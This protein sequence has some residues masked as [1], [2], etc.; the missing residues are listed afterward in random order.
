MRYAVIGSN[1]FS[2]SHFVARLLSSKASVL[3][4]SRS[5]EV[6]RVFRPYSWDDLPGSWQFAQIDIRDTP[7]LT[8]VL[9]TFDPQ[10]V[11]NFAAQSMVA[12]SWEHPDHWYRTNVEALAMLAAELLKLPNLEK[13]VQVTTP[14]VY[15]S[16]EGWISESRNF[17][18]STPYAVSRAAGDMHLMAMH[19]TWG[20]PVCLTRAA[21]VFGPGQQ[22]YRIVPKSILSARLGRKVRLEGGGQSTRSFIHISDVTEA[23]LRIAQNGVPGETYHI[24]TDEIVSIRDLV[25]KICVLTD[26]DFETLVTQVP[27]RPGKDDTYMLSSSR[28]KQEFGWS[29]LTSLETGLEDTVN[30]VDENIEELAQ[31]SEFDV[32][33]K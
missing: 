22:L 21:N 6:A 1:S 29:P 30:W 18:P 23:T 20:F 5:P 19:K 16:T 9:K 32:H 17:R 7:S 4:I 31:A 28:L 33:Q 26:V 25:E 11:V 14:E 8:T 12:Q 27:D 15:G 24:S 2:G 10:V 3:G 13:F